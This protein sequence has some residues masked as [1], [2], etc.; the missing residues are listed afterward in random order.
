[1][2]GHIKPHGHNSIYM[3]EPKLLDSTIPSFAYNMQLTN[4]GLDNLV[5]QFTC[6]WPELEAPPFE[7]FL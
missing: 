7:E 2:Y 6:R 1:M 4:D 5:D 3:I